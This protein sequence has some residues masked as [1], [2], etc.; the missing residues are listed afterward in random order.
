MKTIFF[1]SPNGFPSKN[2]RNVGIFTLEQAKA[3]EQKKNP[4][5]IDLATNKKS[6]IYSEKFDGI[7]IYRIPYAKYN[8]LKICKNFFFFKKVNYQI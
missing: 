7:T 6:E 4:I 1:I 3:L 5:L 8:L 2:N